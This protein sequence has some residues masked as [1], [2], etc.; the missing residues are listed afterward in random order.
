MWWGRAEAME[1]SAE[2]RILIE[3]RHLAS[4]SKVWLE[5]DAV[6]SIVSPLKIQLSKDLQLSLLYFNQLQRSHWEEHQAES[7]Q[8]PG[9]MQHLT[10]F[11]LI[12]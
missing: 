4:G 1:K 9:V 6:A 7:F 11:G 2:D 8:N 5:G 10:N 3:G 12:L